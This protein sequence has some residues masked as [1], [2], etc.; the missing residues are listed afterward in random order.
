[1]AHPVSPNTML[2]LTIDAPHQPSQPL[3]L[4]RGNVCMSR[5]IVKDLMGSLKTIV[6]GEVETWTSLMSEARDIAQQRLVAE[7]Q[8][9]GA[10]GIAGIRFT[11]NCT[12]EVV[13]VL[14]YGTAVRIE[15]QEA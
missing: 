5:N 3:G 10:N 9:L 1:M 11:S 7:A 8:K 4:V 13:E 2:L 15:P 6:G 12:E 14:A